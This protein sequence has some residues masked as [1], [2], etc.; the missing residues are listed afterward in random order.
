MEKDS[1]SESSHTYSLAKL[2]DR[3]MLKAFA[4]MRDMVQEMLED[5]KESIVLQE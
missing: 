2:F 5:R 4:T 3:E 1:N